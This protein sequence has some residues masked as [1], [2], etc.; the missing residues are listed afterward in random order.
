MKTKELLFPPGYFD[1]LIE[2]SEAFCQ[3]SNISPRRRRVLARKAKILPEREIVRQIKGKRLSQD[4]KLILA[5]YN[6]L[7]H[8]ILR[9]NLSQR[10]VRRI[11]KKAG[12]VIPRKEREKKRLR[13]K[14][15]GLFKRKGR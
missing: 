14:H 6:Q 1:S 5:L 13:K 10:E 2:R 9:A 15:K 7:N 8:E 11:R 4:D 3:R 12:L